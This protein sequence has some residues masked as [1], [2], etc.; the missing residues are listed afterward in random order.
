MHTLIEIT[1]QVLIEITTQVLIE[2]TTQVSP[3]GRR[4]QHE[5]KEK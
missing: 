2:I 3:K 4:E 1:T 5:C